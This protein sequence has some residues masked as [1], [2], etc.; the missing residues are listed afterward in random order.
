MF[1]LASSFKTVFST[2]T[3]RYVASQEQLVGWLVA[4][5][6]LVLCS[7]ILIWQVYHW[8]ST[9]QWVFTFIMQRNCAY[10]YE[11][12]GCKYNFKRH[13]V[14]LSIFHFS[15]HFEMS[16]KYQHK[17]HKMSWIAQT[18]IS[19]LVWTDKLLENGPLLT[20]D[21]I[22]LLSNTWLF[23]RSWEHPFTIIQSPKCGFIST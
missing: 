15:W 3:T 23:M 17:N 22:H 6:R 18:V 21:E 9:S 5:I 11:F 13:S 2:I 20:F 1:S 4:Y 19:L 7:L 8:L 14:P 12:T 16:R 10:M